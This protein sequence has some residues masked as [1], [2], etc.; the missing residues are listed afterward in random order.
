VIKIIN[1]HDPL[2]SLVIPVK[3]EGNNIKNTIE[4][5]FQVK[6]TYPFE[7]VVVDDGSNDRCCDF[8]STL[9]NKKIKLINTNG[10]GAAR[11]RNIGAHHA[12]GAYLIF[13]DAHVFF[14]DSWIESLLD[15]IQKGLADATTPGIANVNNHNHIGLGQTLN[16]NLEVQWHLN[17]NTLFP[18][19]VL[20]GGCFAIS[21]EVFTNIGGFDNKLK[22]W[23]YEDVELSIKMWLFG[24]TCYVQPA[25]KILHVFRNSHPY[26]VNWDDYY[27]N[28]IRMAY[29]HFSM[30]RIDKCRRLIKYSDPAII[31]SAVMNS[32]VLEQRDKYFIRR[33]FD[34]EWFMTYFRIPF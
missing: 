24:Y 15:P 28:L 2:V 10:I 12:R 19:A 9:E 27:Y 7:I 1:I 33:K 14:E 18:T 4:S 8:I 6:T 21:K 20:P 13:C 26:K 30:E 29:S 11:A 16:E 5:A 23:G 31:E 34:D 17:L 32:N 22:V 25:V 3:N